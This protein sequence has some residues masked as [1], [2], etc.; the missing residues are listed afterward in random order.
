MHRCFFASSP[1]ATSKTYTCYHE[2]HLLRLR[3]FWFF[4]LPLCGLACLPV[5][6][7]FWPG[8]SILEMQCSVCQLYLSWVVGLCCADPKWLFVYLGFWLEG[9]FLPL[10]KTFFGS[11]TFNLHWKRKTFI[12]I[13]KL[14]CRSHNYLFVCCIHICGAINC[15]LFCFSAINSR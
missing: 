4:F 10:L 7:G 13:S 8:S 11:F 12:P 6:R 9:I 5:I 15:V 2:R 3:V 1:R 14:N